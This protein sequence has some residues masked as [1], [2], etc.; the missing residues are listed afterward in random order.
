[1]AQQKSEDRDKPQ[2]R[3]KPVVTRVVETHAGGEA[4]PVD[5]A[6]QQ[7]LLISGTAVVLAQASGRGEAD[8]SLGRP[9]THAVPKPEITGR[10]ATVATMDN[11]VVPV[12]LRLE[13]V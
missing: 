13:L 7:P 1:M 3:R 2:D 9:A 11:I 12:Q 10:R 4:I 8:C 6:P 5:E